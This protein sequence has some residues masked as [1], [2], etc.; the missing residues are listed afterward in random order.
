[1]MSQCPSL[2]IVRSQL[3]VPVSKSLEENWIPYYHGRLQ[4]SASKQAIVSFPVWHYMQT[5]IWL[6]EGDLEGI[7]AKGDTLLWLHSDGSCRRMQCKKEAVTLYSQFLI[8]GLTYWTISLRTVT[9]RA[10]HCT[11]SAKQ[12]MLIK[13]KIYFMF[14]LR[15]K[16]TED[17]NAYKLSIVDK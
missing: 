17:R 16:A 7:G 8:C 13:T 2:P 12:K 3:N 15:K 4:G 9:A 6:A 14:P 10:I 1:M 5:K 11:S